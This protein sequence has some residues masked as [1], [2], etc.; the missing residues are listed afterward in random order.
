MLSMA[1]RGFFSVNTMRAMSTAPT[2]RTHRLNETN[3][4]SD[5][6]M[7]T[8]MYISSRIRTVW[9]RNAFFKRCE[10]EKS[11]HDAAAIKASWKLRSSGLPDR[12]SVEVE[13]NQYARGLIETASIQM[14]GIQNA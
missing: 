3:G 1:A 13:P 9:P 5:Q 11:T 2:S 6:S 7:L 4:M 12:S 8:N 14:L 10:R